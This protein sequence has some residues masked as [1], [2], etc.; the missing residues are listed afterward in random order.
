MLSRCLV[1]DHIENKR[2]NMV[3]EL[4]YWQKDK[5]Y[6]RLGIR[7]ETIRYFNTDLPKITIPVLPGRNIATLVESAAMNE[8][9][10]LWAI[11]QPLHLHKAYQR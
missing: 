11:T 8:K 7:A 3:V 5:E 2:I 4:E 6:D 1:V 10:K 9:L